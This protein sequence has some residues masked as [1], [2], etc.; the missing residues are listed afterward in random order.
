MG[1]GRT[2]AS[3]G[4]EPGQKGDQGGEGREHDDGGRGLSGSERDAEC[5]R[6]GVQERVQAGA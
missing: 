3:S 4:R 2:S 6:A 1:Y 5:E